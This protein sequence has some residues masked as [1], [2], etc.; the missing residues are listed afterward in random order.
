VYPAPVVLTATLEKGLPIAGADVFAQV[1]APDKT[2]TSFTL[3]DDGVSPDSQAGDGKYTGTLIYGQNGLY[4][5]SILTNNSSGKAA[6]TYNG[7]VMSAD[8]NGNLPKLIGNVP[9]GTNFSRSASLQVTTS[10][11]S[12]PPV[13]DVN[14]DKCTITA[15]VGKKSQLDAITCSGTFADP[16]SGTDI[17][18]ASAVHIKIYTASNPTGYS[19]TIALDPT[20]GKKGKYTCKYQIPKGSPG[21]AITA[22]NLDLNKQTFSFQAQ[23]ISLGGLS[24][25]LSI[26]I[27]IGNYVGVGYASENIVNGKKLI[28]TSLMTGYSDTI[29][30]EKWTVKPGKAGKG[31]SLSIA[32]SVASKLPV[33]TIFPGDPVTH[34]GSCTLTWGSSTF[35]FDLQFHYD[36]YYLKHQGPIYEIPKNTVAGGG[37]S[38]KGLIDFQ[39]GTFTVQITGAAPGSLATTSPVPF[40]ITF[41]GYTASDFATKP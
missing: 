8:T 13:S 2:I 41:T 26:K 9:V 14:I 16:I 39:K 40:G 31:D 36:K 10:G 21:G 5:I 17:N 38:V 37:E 7:A 34:I 28:P 22:F 33:P 32:G 20:K 6:F 15:G 4:K 23:N 29:K 11:Y 25:P 18:S 27:E 24:C 12:P 1:E 35:V 3:K 19:G 30:A